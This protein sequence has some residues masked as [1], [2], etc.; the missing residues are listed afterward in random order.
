MGG[1]NMTESAVL[2]DDDDD[3]DDDDD[4][5]VGARVG[6]CFDM[7]SKVGGEKHGFSKTAV[8]RMTNNGCFMKQ[9]KFI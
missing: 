2:Y 6:K 7:M 5:D 3:D 8:V 1:F 9:S 4:G